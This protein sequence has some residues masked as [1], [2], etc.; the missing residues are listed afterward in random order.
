MAKQQKTIII[1]AIIAIALM[2]FFPPVER[3]VQDGSNIPSGYSI[4]VDMS[5]LYTIN[6]TRLLLQWAA[7]G[8]VAS[9][10]MFVY[11]T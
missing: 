3:I 6:I 5:R 9:G 4:L 8:A 7:I 11:K 2:L 10:L 1:L